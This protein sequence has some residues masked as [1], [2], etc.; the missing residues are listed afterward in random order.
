MVKQIVKHSVKRSKSQ[1]QLK[2]VEV[3][4]PKGIRIPVFALKGQCP[5]PL[6]DGGNVCVYKKYS[7]KNHRWLQAVRV[8]TQTFSASSM[9][10]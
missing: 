2:T 7:R 6:D 10:P 5:R 8:R 1:L 3:G 4:A 9:L